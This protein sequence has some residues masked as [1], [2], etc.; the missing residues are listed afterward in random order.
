M[1]IGLTVSILIF[2]INIFCKYFTFCFYKKYYGV[3]FIQII[4]LTFYYTILGA[5]FILKKW[6]LLFSRDAFNWQ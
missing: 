6:I 1:V 2:N 5:F 4:K 3:F